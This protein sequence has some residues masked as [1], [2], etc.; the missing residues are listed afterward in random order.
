MKE[1]MQIVCPHCST[2]NRVESTRLGDWPQCGKC[3]HQLF[4]ATPV[5]LTGAN[6]EKNIS[7]NAIPVVVDFWASWCGPCKMMAPIFHQ[8][9]AQLE[10]RYRLAKVNMETE[11]GIAQQLGIQSI[12]TTI[13]FKNG[14][15]IARRVGAM[16]L[17]TLLRWVQAN[18]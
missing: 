4:V 13:I 1:Q 6:F 17:G 15:E 18:G 9:A 8:A 11:P 2:G 7:S 3:K 10:P 16:D 12:P 14:K 5:E